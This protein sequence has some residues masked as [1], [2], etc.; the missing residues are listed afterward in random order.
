MTNSIRITR[1]LLDDVTAAV[2]PERLLAR[3]ETPLPDCYLTPPDERVPEC[4]RYAAAYPV[5][6]E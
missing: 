2:I 3:E 5:S 4:C 6:G 1:L